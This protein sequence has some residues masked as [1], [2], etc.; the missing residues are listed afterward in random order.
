MLRKVHFPLT[1]AMCKIRID[2]SHKTNR[3]RRQTPA[4]RPISSLC[5]SAIAMEYC[6]EL[7]SI[8]K[9]GD[10]VV[11][12]GNTFD[13]PSWHL[14]RT[15]GRRSITFDVLSVLGPSNPLVRLVPALSSVDHGNAKGMKE[16]VWTSKTKK[17]TI[18]DVRSWAYVVS[19][20]LLQSGQLTR[21]HGWADVALLRFKCDVNKELERLLS[22]NKI[23]KEH[24]PQ[25]GLTI[26]S[27]IKMDFFSTR[28]YLS[29]MM[30][31]IMCSARQYSTTAFS[32]KT[33]MTK[34]MFLFLLKFIHDLREMMG[35]G[36]EN[37]AMYEMRSSARTEVVTNHNLETFLRQSP[38]RT[39]TITFSSANCMELFKAV[40]GSASLVGRRRPLKR[41]EICRIKESDKINVVDPSFNCN[42]VS[43]ETREGED[44]YKMRKAKCRIVMMYDEVNCMFRLRVYYTYYVAGSPEGKRCLQANSLQVSAP[45]DDGLA[46]GLELMLN[47]AVY[48]VDG[49]TDGKVR[50][51]F[52]EDTHSLGLHFDSVVLVDFY[53]A[54]GLANQYAS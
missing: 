33:H 4:T 25:V 32:E 47:G 40:A 12:E 34:L 10:V 30:M 49:R 6:A 28:Q 19:L 36:Y 9:E 11:L 53:E 2:C 1:F 29:T 48:K 52:V 24:Q 42:D 35:A 3:P 14:V 18:N 17:G 45:D 31:K 38:V 39:H 13:G 43:E 8:V 16:I 54:V 21:C 22:S 51:V 26:Q 27:S 15:I 23:F 7:G 20:E 50:C 46:D 41:E 44:F 37:A 5:A